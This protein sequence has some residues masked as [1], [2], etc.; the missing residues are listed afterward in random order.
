[1]IANFSATHRLHLPVVFWY[2]VV[3]F[4][5]SHLISKLVSFSVRNQMCSDRAVLLWYFVSRKDCWWELNRCLKGL[6][7]QAG[8]IPPVFSSNNGGLVDDGARWGTVVCESGHE[9]HTGPADSHVC[10]D[11][12][13][14]DARVHIPVRCISCMRS[15]GRPT[16]AYCLNNVLQLL[17]RPMLSSLSFLF[18]LH[19]DDRR[20]INQIDNV[21]RALASLERDLGDAQRARI[22][23]I[24]VT[25]GGR[26]SSGGKLSGGKVREAV[27]ERELVRK[28]RWVST[29]SDGT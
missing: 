27:E 24:A 22:G 25:A 4:C 26:C 9:R 7:S 16:V 28:K 2:S 6:C 23:A 29:C 13:H 20:G 11:A 8:V 14:M 19:N 10:G 1:M 17:R 12:L 21:A 18:F 3:F 5:T 15:E